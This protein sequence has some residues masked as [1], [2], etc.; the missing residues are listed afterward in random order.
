MNINMNIYIYNI[1][2]IYIYIYNILYTSY[3][4]HQRERSSMWHLDLRSSRDTFTV[5]LGQLNSIVKL[6]TNTST[7]TNS[8]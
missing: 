6:N 5:L 8:D 1:I 3:T 2:Y 4:T 7:D